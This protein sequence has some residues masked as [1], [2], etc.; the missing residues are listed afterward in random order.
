MRLLEASANHYKDI[1]LPR[2]KGIADEAAQPRG[3][4]HAHS[5]RPALK[6]GFLQGLELRDPLTQAPLFSESGPQVSK[7][8]PLTSSSRKSL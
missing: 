4:G 3:T 6:A 5:P 1:A 2:C 8:V 7:R